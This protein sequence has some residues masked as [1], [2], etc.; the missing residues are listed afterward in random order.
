MIAKKWIS[1]LLTAAVMMA[2]LAG[3]GGQAVPEE[4]AAGQT[5]AAAAEEK[6]EPVEVKAGVFYYYGQD[7]FIS[8][9]Q[10]SVNTALEEA[11]IAYENYDAGNDQET[12]MEQIRE[13]ID[14]GCNLLIVNLVDKGASASSSRVCDMAAQAE[15][16]VIFFNRAVESG[17]GEGAVLGGYEDVALVISDPAEAGHLQGQMIGRY[18]ADHYDEV[19]LNDD[20]VITYAMFK[21]EA[22]NQ[23][24]VLRTA[25]AVEDANQVLAEEERQELVYFDPD[26]SDRYQLDLNGSWSAKA[27]EEYMRTNLQLYTEAD[28]NMIELIICNNDDMAEGCI[29][30]LQEKGYNT[31]D[32]QVRIPVFGVDGIDSSLALIEEGLMTGTVKQDTGA[33]AACIALL[34][35]NVHN[36]LELT[37]GTES[38]KKDT[39]HGLDNLIYIPYGDTVTVQ[40]EEE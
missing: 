5:L 35:G 32:S 2:A 23:D 4:T 6:P 24:A 8:R 39:E 28:G 20:N 26:N 1:A 30:A 16:P 10:D 34:A 27:A 40:D 29:R 7:A 37:A 38:Y 12:Q 31:A 22:E 11:G 19:D 33:I 3:C 21:G 25:S 15:I 13:A 14:G 18:V 36:G 9:L 17:G